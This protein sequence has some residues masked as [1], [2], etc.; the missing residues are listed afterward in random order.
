MRAHLHVYI[1]F[2]LAQ[3]NLLRAWLSSERA[4]LLSECGRDWLCGAR[5]SASSQ[6]PRDRGAALSSPSRQAS[7]PAELAETE[8]MLQLARAAYRIGD[9]K[10]SL[11]TARK[12][13]GKGKQE[14]SSKGKGERSKIIRS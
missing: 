11:G 9:G 2:D 12:G 1:M 4:L 6:M 10:R 13:K 5:L 8:N 3:S 7:L 14:D